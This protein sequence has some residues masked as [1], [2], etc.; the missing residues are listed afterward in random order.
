MEF[1]F[2]SWTKVLLEVVWDP[3]GS[4]SQM[5]VLGG[6]LIVEGKGKQKAVGRGGVWPQ[7]SWEGGGRVRKNAHP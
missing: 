6:N 2:E 7:P 1:F 5:W 4:I 3:L